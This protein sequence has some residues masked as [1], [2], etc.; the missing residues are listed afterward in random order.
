MKTIKPLWLRR[1]GGGGLDELV[2]EFEAEW[3]SQQVRSGKGSWR[4]PEL[5]EATA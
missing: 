1:S 3:H 4:C 5:G 2:V